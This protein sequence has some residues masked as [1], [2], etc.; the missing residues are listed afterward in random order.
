[1]GPAER[2]LVCVEKSLERLPAELDLR[3][4]RQT[5]WARI[6]AGVVGGKRRRERVLCCGGGGDVFVHGQREEET[7]RVAVYAAV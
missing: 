2:R 5:L 1:M 7:T 6:L 4:W 3:N